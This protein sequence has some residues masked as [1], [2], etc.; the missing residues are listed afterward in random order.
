MEPV[1]VPGGS[2]FIDILVLTYYYIV[3]FGVSHGVAEA[4]ADVPDALLLAQRQ[5]QQR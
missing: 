1:Q 5:Q 3:T 4:M 2:I